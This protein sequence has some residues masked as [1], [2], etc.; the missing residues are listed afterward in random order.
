[1]RT[2]KQKSVGA[3]KPTSI[4]LSAG[5]DKSPRFEVLSCDTTMRL[6]IAQALAASG[7]SVPPGKL[8]A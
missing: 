6:L 1:M 7:I 3:P 5:E 2:A 4:C 8:E